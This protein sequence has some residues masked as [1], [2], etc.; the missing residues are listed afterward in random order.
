FQVATQPFG[1]RLSA[2]GTARVDANL[3]EVKERGDQPAVPVRCA[4]RSDIRQHSSFL[5]GQ[6][7]STDCR[8]ST[9]AHIGNGARL[10]DRAWSAALRVEQQK[11]RKFRWQVVLVIIIIIRNDFNPGVIDRLANPAAQHVEMANLARVR[12]QMHAW[13]NYRLAPALGKKATLD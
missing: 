2:L 13:F 10:Y 11:S 8:H 1:Q 5:P 7:L 12:L 4:A 9:G 3:I 6:V